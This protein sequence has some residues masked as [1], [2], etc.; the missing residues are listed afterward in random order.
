MAGI[1]GNTSTD[2]TPTIQVNGVPTAGPPY[3]ATASLVGINSGNIAKYEQAFLKGGTVNGSALTDP[4]RLFL[5]AFNN[6]L[7][8]SYNPATQYSV[9]LVRT[10][11]EP[12]LTAISGESGLFLVGGEFPVPVSQ[13]T[14]GRVSVE[15]KPYG[16]GLGYTPVVLSD[17]RISLKMSTEVSELTSVGGFTL[18]TGSSS[19]GGATSGPTLSVPGL[20]VRRAE[21]TVELPS[22]GSMMIAGL[23]ARSSERRMASPSSPGII[24]SSTTSA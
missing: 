18:G 9:G 21:T 13:D 8:S 3:T 15:F 16:V 14:L 4:Q 7:T 5:N 17:G 10:L 2:I 20:N 19:T 1:L 22:G 24:T 12:N 6:N 11:A 23:L